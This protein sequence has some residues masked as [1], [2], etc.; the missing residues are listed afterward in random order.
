MKSFHFTFNGLAGVA[1]GQS[2]VREFSLISIGE[3]NQ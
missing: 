1:L 2:R 3:I